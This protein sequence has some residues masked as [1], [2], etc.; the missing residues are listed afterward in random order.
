MEYAILLDEI[1]QYRGRQPERYCFEWG[2]TANGIHDAMLFLQEHFPFTEISALYLGNEFCEHRIP[3]RDQILSAYRICEN[4]RLE[5]V[6][7]TPPV[8]DAGINK[9]R[10]CLDTVC[11]MQQNPAIVVNDLGVLYLISRHYPSCSI[12]LGRILDKLSHDVRASYD[13]FTAYY[14]ANGIQY[15]RTAVVPEEQ[16]TDALG[17][18]R[19]KRLEFDLPAVGISL[20]KGKHYSLYYPYCYLTTGRLCMMRS[21]HLDAAEKFLIQQSQCAKPCHALQVEKR[22]PLNGYR[23]ENGKRISEQ[24]LFQRGNT[25]FYIPRDPSVQDIRQ[26]DRIVLQV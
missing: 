19:I 10:A 8:T 1:E 6:L 12:I 11:S 18:C 3:R 5:F 15:A 7:V 14:G 2:S 20:A 13:E 21:L 25:V 26:F 4:D 22:K 23:F 17:Q 9:L 16:Y 24:Y